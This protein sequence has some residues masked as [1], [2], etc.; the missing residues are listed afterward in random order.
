MK[1]GAHVSTSGG[2]ATGFERAE[3]IGAE[4]M[5]IF[6]SAPQQWGTAKLTDEQAEAFRA[7]D[8]G[9]R[10]RAGVH[11]WQVPD[12]PGERGRQDLPHVAQ[13]AP[14]QPEHRRPHRRAS[15]SSSTPAA[16]KASASRRC[17][18][19]SARPA[20]K[21]LDETPPET[22]LIFEN[23]AGGGDT[24]GSKFHDLG[25]ILRRIDNPRARVCI[26]TCH[27]FAAGYDLSTTEGVAATIE[28]L[29][30]EIG[31]ANV[32]AM[33]CNDSKTRAGRRP[34]PAREHRRGQDRRGGVRSAA[35][36]A[37]AARRAAA[38]RGARLQARRR[39]QG[40]GPAEHRSGEGDPRARRRAG[41]VGA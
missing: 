39:R 8:G 32:A 37:G 23:S 12:E 13:H 40:A 18:S 41:R 28:E 9:E 5:Q 22:L 31:C 4:C 2:L 7:R 10:H 14:Q 36:A 16:T 38:A 17:S 30:R 15:A 1:V 3:A 19:R 24:I 33:H 35:R 26:D 20:P 11:P 29:E 6:E 21:V 25:E 34:R 27:A